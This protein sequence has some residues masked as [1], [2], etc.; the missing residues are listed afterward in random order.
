M[1]LDAVLRAAD[2]EDAAAILALNNAC[3]PAVSAVDLERMR[4]FLESCPYFR[5]VVVDERTGPR[6]A[7]A[8]R[9]PHP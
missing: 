1:P 8:P 9:L 6:L 2:L 4:W 5:L 3:A 7:V